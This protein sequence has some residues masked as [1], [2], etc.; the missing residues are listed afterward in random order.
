MPWL[1][2]NLMRFA[3]DLLSPHVYT[4]VTRLQPPSALRP[5]HPGATPNAEPAEPLLYHKPISAPW[6]SSAAEADDLR[7]KEAKKT[8][9]GR[10][11]GSSSKKLP[12]TDL[13]AMWDWTTKDPEEPLV[14]RRGRLTSYAT[15]SFVGKVTTGAGTPGAAGLFSPSLNL[16]SNGLRSP[17]PSGAR[18]FALPGLPA[19]AMRTNGA[20]GERLAW[21]DEAVNSPV[22]TPNGPGSLLI[23]TSNRRT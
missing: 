20:S 22:Q 8:A 11:S 14:A 16:M 6:N 19:S 21:E 1:Q 10:D 18:G 9:N 15:A 5:P 2:G 7:R 23:K 17:A 3:R 13:F 4:K 12:D